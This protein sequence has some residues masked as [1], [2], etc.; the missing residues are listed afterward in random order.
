MI[1]NQPPYSRRAIKALA[2]CLMKYHKYS[3]AGAKAAARSVALKDSANWVSRKGHKNPRR[4]SVFGYVVMSKDR[5]DVLY[6]QCGLD[7]K[8]LIIK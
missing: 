2:N 6:I 7:V 1:I 8:P 5:D 4:R 3:R